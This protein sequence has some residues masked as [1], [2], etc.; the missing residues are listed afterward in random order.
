MSDYEDAILLVC[1]RNYNVEYIVT[2]DED[3]IKTDTAIPAVSPDALL[4]IL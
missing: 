4:S 1:G 2:R 3:F